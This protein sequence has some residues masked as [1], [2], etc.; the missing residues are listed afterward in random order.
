MYAAGQVWL[1][2]TYFFILIHMYLMELQ[3]ATHP[4]NSAVQ[5]QFVR[6]NKSPLF[7]CTVETSVV[8][9]PVSDHENPSLV[10]YST[11][12]FV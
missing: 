2:F 4:V 1:S 7:I 10:G 5:Q 3:C 12:L 6:G 9:S 11:A 8:T